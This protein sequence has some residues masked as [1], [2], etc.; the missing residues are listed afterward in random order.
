[1]LICFAGYLFEYALILI[2]FMISMINNSL[3]IAETLFWLDACSVSLSSLSYYLFHDAVCT[4]RTVI[5]K[6]DIDI[7][8]FRY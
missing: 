4:S 2:L 8:V 7:A 1:M 5:F 6:I 3:V